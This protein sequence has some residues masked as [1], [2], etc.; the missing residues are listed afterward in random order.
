MANVLKD[1]LNRRKPAY[2]AARFVRRLLPETIAQRILSRRG[3]ASRNVYEGTTRK[4]LNAIQKAG[5]GPIFGERA[6]LTILEAGTGFYNPA[7][8]P[9]LLSGATR[10]I[11]LEPFLGNNP[12]YARFRERFDDLLAFAKKDPGYP[13]PIK[14]TLPRVS[15]GNLPKGVELSARLWEDTHLPG[16][17]LDG[18]FS[19]SVLEHLRQPESV[20]RECGRIVRPGGF[21]INTIDMRDHFFRYPLEMLKYS[22]AGWERLTTA[23]GGSGYQNRWRVSRWLEALSMHGFDTTIIPLTVNEEL[24]AREKPYLH[25]EFRNLPLDELSLLAATL[26]SRRRAG[27][28]SK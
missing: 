9:L 18:I 22:E 25:E 2:I 14:E 13:L 4:Y 26:V 23:K 17:S 5:L 20:L 3:V 6:S 12:D 24:A 28:T 10:L 19:S 8:A 7:T 1:L 11:L 16:A 27:E 21:M 15:V